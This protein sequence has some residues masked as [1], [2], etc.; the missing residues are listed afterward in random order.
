MKFLEAKEKLLEM[1][2]GKYCA[3]EFDLNVYSNGKEKTTCRVYIA[4]HPYENGLTWN[5]ALEKM[6]ERVEYIEPKNEELP[7]VEA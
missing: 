2:K 4:G 7:E 5:E 6:R 3:I 1:A